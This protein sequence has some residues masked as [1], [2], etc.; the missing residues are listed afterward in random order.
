MGMKTTKSEVFQVLK[1][2]RAQNFTKWFIILKY[3]SN[4][5]DK[6]IL[7]LMRVWDAKQVRKCPQNSV[8]MGSKPQ[9]EVIQVGNRNKDHFFRF[10]FL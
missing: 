2:R 10:L 7:A 5:K 3:I 9:L 4:E 8:E 6:L 1:P